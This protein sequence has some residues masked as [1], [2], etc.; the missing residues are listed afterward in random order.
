[1]NII[2]YDFENK[3]Q[4]IAEA[5]VV[6]L[7]GGTIV[8]PTETAYALGADFFSPGACKTIYT[9]KSRDEK[10]PLPVIVP[11]IEYAT[12]LVK[13]SQ[14]ATR[15]ATKFWPGPLTLVLPFL[16]SEE[17]PHHGDGFLALRVSSHPVANSISHTFGRPLVATS[18][19]VSD[20]KPCYTIEDFINELSNSS[21]QPDLII[22]VGPLPK[23]LPSTV[24]KDD[25]KKTV[26]LRKG[27]IDISGVT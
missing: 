10:K 17:W 7:S 2:K 20:S 11:S 12:T 18:A 19:N 24:V 16:Y 14:S 8:Y 3:P 27:P 13:F 26:V 21:A 1:M 25:G 4:I 15:L 6:L 23:V 22:D 9:I 5:L